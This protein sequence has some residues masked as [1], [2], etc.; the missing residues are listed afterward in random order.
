M[1]VQVTLTKEY[2]EQLTKQI[3]AVIDKAI[4]NKLAKMKPYKRYMTRVELQKYLHIGASTMEQLKRHGL[5]YIVIGNKHLFD[6]EEVNEIFDKL[7]T[8][9]TAH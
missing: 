2:A 4:E 7:K 1:S 5:T 6:I 9:K 8:K 3:E